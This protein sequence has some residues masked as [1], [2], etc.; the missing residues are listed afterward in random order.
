[1]KL[2]NISNKKGS[3]AAVTFDKD[4]EYNITELQNDI[5]IP[6][7]DGDDLH[8]TVMYST[9]HIPEYEELG[10]I[11]PA[12][13]GQFSHYEKFGEDKDVLVLI[14]NCPEL[15]SRWETLKSYGAKWDFPDFQAHITLAYDAAEINIDELRP[16][17]G[18]INIISEYGEDLDLDWEDGK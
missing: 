5:G 12:W 13:T 4:T 10:D 2:S 8:S 3:Y 16:Y 11:D 9:D 15:T 14:Y 18:P 1:M 6:T 7:L 17:K